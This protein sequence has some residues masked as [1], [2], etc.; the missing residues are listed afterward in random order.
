MGKTGVGLKNV[1]HIL[2]ICTCRPFDSRE[3]A[4][5]VWRGWHVVNITDLRASTKES[6][7]RQLHHSFIL[8]THMPLFLRT[9]HKLLVRWPRCEQCKKSLGH[10]QMITTNRLNGMQTAQWDHSHCKLQVV[11]RPPAGDTLSGHPPPRLRPQWQ[12]LLE[13]MT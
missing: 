2:Y 4:F 11:Q 6:A 3:P 5:Q 13:V 9:K 7:S 12:G 8:C 1:Q 10:S